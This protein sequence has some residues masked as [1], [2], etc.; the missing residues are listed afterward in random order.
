M[1]KEIGENSSSNLLNL[2]QDS[3]KMVP[4]V[5]LDKELITDYGFV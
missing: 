1:I 3:V 2:Q 5:N 4:I